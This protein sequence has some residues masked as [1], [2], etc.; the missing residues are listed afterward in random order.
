MLDYVAKLVW[1]Q[2]HNKDTI[3]VK[4]DVYDA[5]RGRTSFLKVARE[6]VDEKTIVHIMLNA[7]P[8]TYEGF[9]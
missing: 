3:F 5:H 2:K 4:Q 1:N 9:I 8:V 6:V 7:L